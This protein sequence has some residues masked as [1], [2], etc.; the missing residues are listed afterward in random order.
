[1]REYAFTI[2]EHDADR[3]WIVSQ[4][5]TGRSRCPT[6]GVL[7]V[8]A[9]VVALGPVYVDRDVAI[10]GNGCWLR[11]GRAIGEEAEFRFFGELLRDKGHVV[12]PG[13]AFAKFA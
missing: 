12:K 11:R 10:A 9:R 7:L 13:S 5:S 8:G 2:T 3:P 1:M 4:P 6:H